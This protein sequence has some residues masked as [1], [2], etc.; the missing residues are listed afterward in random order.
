[1][2]IGLSE[3][4]HERTPSRNGYSLCTSAQNLYGLHVLDVLVGHS[5][6]K[7]SGTKSS[8]N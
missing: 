5:F 8:E 1:M 2:L 6:R 4:S 7:S 3:V